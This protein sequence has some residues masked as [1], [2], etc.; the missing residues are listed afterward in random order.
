MML[1]IREAKKCSIPEA[2]KDCIPR[3]GAVIAI[4]GIAIARSPRV[5][6]DHAE[7]LALEMLRGQDLARAT[8][9][10]TLEPCTSGVRSMPGGSCTDRLIQAQVKKVVI[11]MVD[12]N[13]EI[14]GKSMLA[15]QRAKI[16][17]ELFPHRLVRRICRLNED[18]I[19]AQE[20]LGIKITSMHDGDVWE[21]GYVTLRGTYRN[22]PRDVAY[23]MVHVTE[24]GSRG[25]PP[26]WWPQT[27]ISIFP[28]S[29]TEWEAVVQFGAEQ[30][31]TVCVVRAN[32][33]GKEMINYYHEM[34]SEREKVIDAIVRHYNAPS[35][36]HVQQHV[37]PMLW[38]LPVTAL[39]K[40]LYVESSAK[41]EIK[42]GHWDK[43][44][45]QLVSR[46]P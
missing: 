12:P 38:P 9:F 7:M 5:G 8:V 40:G 29:N 39:R 36:K 35:R 11:G 41:I 26:G 42:G 24:E 20:S 13:R 4:D 3:V 2:E 45:S 10:T 22:D 31:V 16:A 44:W 33:L 43:R 19:R 25:F 27:P 15:L 17:V 46:K 32:E 18:F 28:G 23:A 6:G 34:G 21:R 30:E 37:A 14:C 1:A